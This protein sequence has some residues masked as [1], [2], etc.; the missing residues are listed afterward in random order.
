LARLDQSQQWLAEA[1]EEAEAAAMPT[2]ALAALDIL[3]VE[4]A[5][6]EESAS[7]QDLLQGQS[8]QAVLVAAAMS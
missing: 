2:V 8:A 6:L 7:A 1:A 3:A 5:A 4:V